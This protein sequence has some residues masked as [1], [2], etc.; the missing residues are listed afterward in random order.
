M[1]LMGAAKRDC[2]IRVLSVVIAV[3]YGLKKVI[4]M[5]GTFCVSRISIR[6]RL[7]SLLGC[8]SYYQSRSI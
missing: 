1:S 6:V 2:N 5:V 3:A 4:I 7:V 8:T